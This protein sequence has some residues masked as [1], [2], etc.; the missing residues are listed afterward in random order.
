MITPFEDTEPQLGKNVFVASSALVL[1]DVA[2]G[3][4]CGVWYGAVIRG[5]FDLPS[6]L[7]RWNAQT[8]LDKGRALEVAGNPDKAGQAYGRALALLPDDPQAREAM[9]RLGRD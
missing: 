4:D 6:W 1:G 3:D 8:Y 7:R 9:E 2:L 5:T